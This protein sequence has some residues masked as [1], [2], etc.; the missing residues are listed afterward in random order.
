MREYWASDLAGE[1]SQGDL[2][3]DAWIGAAPHPRT[4]LLRGPTQKGN[5]NFWQESAWKADAQGFGHFLAR[6]KSHQALVL[7]QNCEI[8]KN[9]GKAPVL[10]APVLGLASIPDEKMRDTVRAG[11]RFA[12]FYLP[13][14]E[15]VLPE[16]YVDLRAI[17]YTARAGLAQLTRHGSAAEKGSAALIAQLVAF[18]TRIDVDEIKA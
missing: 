4:A 11:N 16:S 2:L 14:L 18:F 7:S 8:D 3:S 6:G 12:F 15:G 9:G 10:I 13:S 1:L 17:T 5:L